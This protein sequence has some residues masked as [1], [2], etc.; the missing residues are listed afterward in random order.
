MVSVIGSVMLMLWYCVDVDRS[1]WSRRDEELTAVWRVPVL[2]AVSTTTTWLTTPSTLTTWARCR[3]QPRARS[4]RRR[5]AAR[6]RRPVETRAT[7]PARPPRTTTSRR[8]SY[9]ATPPTARRRRVVYSRTPASGRSRSWACCRSASIPPRSR[10]VAGRT[11]NTSTRVPS[12]SDATSFRRLRRRQFTMD[13]PTA[14]ASASAALR[15]RR[16]PPLPPDSTDVCSTWTPNRTRH[17]P[18]PEFSFQ[19]NGNPHVWR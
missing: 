2:C 14:P 9:S 10:P 8:G 3:H 12:S 17:R 5:P 11:S 19:R 15:Q 6:P 7:R 18:P 4:S 13:Q 16:L 1:S